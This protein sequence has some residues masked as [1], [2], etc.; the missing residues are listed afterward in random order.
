[1]TI[2]INSYNRANPNL[3]SNLKSLTQA[4]KIIRV[5]ASVDAQAIKWT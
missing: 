2:K 1:M 5:Q 4:A 3:N